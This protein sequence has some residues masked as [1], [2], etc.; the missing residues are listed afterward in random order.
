M[1]DWVE[2]SP[3]AIAATKRVRNA[4]PASR[5]GEDGK[6]HKRNQHGLGAFVYALG[7][8]LRVRTVAVGGVLRKQLIAQCD[9]RGFMVRGLWLQTKLTEERH[10]PEAEHIERGDRHGDQRHSPKQRAAVG[11]AKYLGEDLVLGEEAGEGGEAGDGEDRH[12]HGP[13]R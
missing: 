10:V 6:Q 1:G 9:A 2:E 7:M 11:R 12:S 13:E 3:E 8:R 5:D 4:D